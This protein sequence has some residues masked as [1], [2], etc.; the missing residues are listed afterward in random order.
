MGRKLLIV[1]SPAKAR[2]IQK[3]LGAD[4]KVQ[5]SM[6]HVRDLPKSKLGVDIEHDFAP[7]YEISSDKSKIISE[8]RSAVKQADAIYLATDPDREGDAI[9]W[10][11]LEAVRVPKNKP[12]YRITFHEITKQAVQEALQHPRN[13]DTRLVDAQQARRVL[14]RLVGYRLSPLLWDKV[15]R[16]LSA[17]RVQSV[18]VR[19]VVER[20]REIENFKPRE[21]WS[22]EA[23]LAKL[24]GDERVFRAVLIERNGKKLDK[25][26][27]ASQ[28]AAEAIVRDLDGAQYRVATITRKDKKRTPAP[29]FTTSTLQQEASRKL[30]FG[31]KK[32]MLIAQQLYEGVDIGAEGTVGL[33]T[34]MRT[35]S[36][37]V[38][39]QAQ[40][41]ARALIRELY[42]AEYVP[43]RPNVYKTK[44][45]G[46]Q[47]AHEAIRPTSVRRRPE[48]LRGVLNRDQY[49]LYELIW[50][51][52]VASQMA[53]AIFDSTTVD[54]AAGRALNGATPPYLFRATGSVLTFAGFLAVYNVSLDDGEEDEDREALLPP[55]GEG[56]HLRLVE[57]L[58]L[59]HW[60]QPPP[61]YTE[62]SLVKELERLGIGRPSTYAPTLATIEARDYVEIVDKKLVPTTLGRIVTDLLVEHFPDVVDYNF[63]SQM[64]QQLDDIAEGERQWVPVVREFYQP[65][66]R[67]LEKAQRE[68]RSVKGEVQITELTCPQCGAALAIRLGRNGEFLACTNEACSFTG[69]LQRDA[70]G[71]VRLAAQPQ[72][73][74]GEPQICDKCGRSMVIKQGRYGP[75]LACSGYP[76]CK[77]VR[78]LTRTSEGT[79]A[80][81]EQVTE[82]ACPK[83]G[84]PMIRKAGRWGPYLACSDYPECK[85]IQKLDRQGQPKPPAQITERQ[86]P[87][88]GRHLALKQGRYGPFLSC[89]GYPRCRYIEKL[90]ADGPPPRILSDEEVAAL[91]AQ[92]ISAKSEEPNATA[93]KRS[94]ATRSATGN[95]SSA[96]RSSPTR[97][98]PRAKQR[99]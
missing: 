85:T 17:G 2:T 80:L 66:E 65:F 73:A 68:M 34:Y 42:G 78:N 6:G 82:F 88:C 75:F 61:R 87:Q 57:L 92:A 52:F 36:V 20:E 84:K 11:V 40:D 44:T 86:C 48:Q 70:E 14:D 63:T 89:T 25:F 28:A 60:T 54:I 79:L 67:T 55:L 83:C 41:E 4:F 33:I 74:E 45:K 18:A 95:G 26:A 23:D 91:P 12:V 38:S 35:D 21:Y 81:A 32:T 31:A 58:P 13:I 50:K 51:R 43:A 46:A 15:R 47:E 49:R 72:L 24:S 8:L 39:Q 29:P 97:H 27:I 77:N 30:G 9:A 19:L 62:A 37:S 90:P 98:A 5:A 3:Y 71:N 56:E 69:D 76:Q 96:K 99:A 53:A 59:Q 22:I 7:E 10:H 93:R 1:E 64:E 94:S 16:G